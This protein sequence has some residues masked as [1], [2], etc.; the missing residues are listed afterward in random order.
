[1]LQQRTI[2]DVLYLTSSNMLIIFFFTLNLIHVHH[3]LRLV[4]QRSKSEGWKKPIDVVF[5]F[6]SLALYEYPLH[7]WI[8]TSPK[9]TKW[10]HPGS[11][12]SVSFTTEHRVMIRADYIIPA[13]AGI[14]Y[15][16]GT[17]QLCVFYPTWRNFWNAHTQQ[18]LPHGTNDFSP[19]GTWQ[20]RDARV[21]HYVFNTTV[22]I[23]QVH[24]A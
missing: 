17:L 7:A 1:M 2:L 21:I 4:L 5:V 20:R 23:L 6:N 12:S 10:C 22:C 24:S 19:M 14:S 18:R 15:S 16:V 9:P 8:S 13:V 11:H 3:Y